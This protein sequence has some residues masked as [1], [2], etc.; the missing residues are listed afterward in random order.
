VDDEFDALRMSRVKDGIID[1]DEDGILVR[2]A[3]LHGSRQIVIPWSLR[4]FSS[5]CN[6][7]PL[8]QPTR[9]AENVFHDA[10]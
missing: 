10:S 3:P 4:P 5:G 9:G 8:S 2:I 7:S 1:V 6:T